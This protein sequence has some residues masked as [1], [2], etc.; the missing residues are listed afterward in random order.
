MVMLLTDLLEGRCLP[1]SDV[2]TQGEWSGWLKEFNSAADTFF[3]LTSV[4]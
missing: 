2:S 3:T 4:L 1:S